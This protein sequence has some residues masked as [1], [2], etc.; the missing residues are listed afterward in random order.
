MSHYNGDHVENNFNGYKRKY[1]KD[2]VDNNSQ[3]SS[4]D[5]P[6]SCPTN[7]QNKKSRIDAMVIDSLSNSLLEGQDIP[8]SDENLSKEFSRNF[9]EKIINTKDFNTFEKILSEWIKNLD[10]KNNESILELMQNHEQTKFWFSSIIGF[11]YQFGLSCDVDDDRALEFYLL[12]VN[13][14]EKEFLN[15]NF[16]QT[17]NNK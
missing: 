2:V 16:L 15:Y 14:D 17:N 9:Y 3:K 10:K 1:K 11:F 7:H 4:R 8:K 13:N 12:A 5:E 6:S